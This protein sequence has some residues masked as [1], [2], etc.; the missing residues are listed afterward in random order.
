MPVSIERGEVHRRELSA[1]AL[2]LGVDEVNPS[3]S[4]EACLAEVPQTDSRLQYGEEGRMAQAQCTYCVRRS[5]VELCSRQEYSSN[6]T[7]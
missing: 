1:P 6:M 4:A 5:Y 2:G 7:P 3:P